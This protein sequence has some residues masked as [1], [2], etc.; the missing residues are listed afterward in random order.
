MKPETLSFIYTQN[1]LYEDSKKW[2]NKLKTTIENENSIDYD[3]DS[4]FIKFKEFLLDVCGQLK[5][6]E[7]SYIWLKRN[8]YNI[9]VEQREIIGLFEGSDKVATY[10]EAVTIEIK[11]DFFKKHIKG[12]YNL[13]FIDTNIFLSMGY[14]TGWKNSANLSS[15]NM[16]YVDI[17][18]ID[19]KIAN[20]DE[21]TIRNYIKTICPNDVLPNY[22]NASGHGF[23]L[24][25]LLDRYDLKTKDGFIDIKK[26]DYFININAKLITHFKA[27]TNCR[28]LG[29]YLRI[30]MSN[31]IKPNKIPVKS[32]LFTFTNRTRRFNL[33]ELNKAFDFVD[34]KK[35][36]YIEDAKNETV[37]KRKETLK[38]NKGMDRTLT[39][40]SSFNAFLNEYKIENISYRQILDKKDLEG[41]KTVKGKNSKILRTHKFIIN[42]FG[43][44]L[45][46][47]NPTIKE[48]EEILEIKE[49]YNEA[50][51]RLGIEE[52]KDKKIIIKERKEIEKKKKITTKEKKKIKKY[53]LEDVDYYEATH[54]TKNNTVPRDIRAKSQLERQ[55]NDFFYYAKEHGYI[56]EGRR[57]LCAVYMCYLLKNMRKLDKK[58]INIVFSMLSVC[59]NIDFYDDLY[60]IIIKTL[61]KKKKKQVFS[62]K[63]E[64]MLSILE[65]NEEN[66]DNYFTILNKEKRN[67]EKASRYRERKKIKKQEDMINKLPI[68]I[69]L[70]RNK[71][72]IDK[73]IYS[74]E[75]IEKAKEIIKKQD[76]N[77]FNKERLTDY[78]RK[79]SLIYD[80]K[81]TRSKY[82]PRLERIERFIELKK[83][84]KTHEEIMRELNISK[85]TYDSYS[86][87]SLLTKN[88]KD[89]YYN[90]LLPDIIKDLIHAKRKVRNKSKKYLTKMKNLKLS[91]M[92]ENRKKFTS[93]DIVNKKQFV[94][95]FMEELGLKD[96]IYLRERLKE[97]ICGF[98]IKFDLN[99]FETSDSVEVYDIKNNEL[100][101]YVNIN[102]K[103]LDEIIKNNFPKRFHEE[104]KENLSLP[105]SDKNY[106]YTKNWIAN[107]FATRLR[108][109]FFG[110]DDY[111]DY[112][113]KLDCGEI[114]LL[115]NIKNRI[116]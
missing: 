53:I 14:Y 51:K 66:E 95:I 11:E 52:K 93:F 115:K 23:H 77:I 67:R 55:L 4:N 41:L 94:D 33:E 39:N 21:E 16:I 113:R 89:I 20:G 68:L 5:K 13:S 87:E 97:K 18:G 81:I 86:L 103:N 105:W 22:V 60:N 114:I 84:N 78:K 62:L 49:A 90:N 26:R 37:R 106:I 15:V 111:A 30:P 91:L 74:E 57:N 9:P 25:W 58:D 85:R 69:N 72:W 46:S 107:Y 79:M 70:I 31:N 50:C 38:K 29:R 12:L 24:I 45:S 100:E 92:K 102:R 54:Y 88:T 36:H 34:I 8:D 6:D 104:I 1:K 73:N 99:F 116:F 56:R 112:I 109:L 28:D 61:S 7:V 108:N 64:T 2:I 47:L 10:S 83:E 48:A 42:I 110:M 71:K 17:D 63:N 19:E 44:K 98:K 76:K 65:I 59:F 40:P 96:D 35:D 3:K 101:I 75:M 27:D 80:A 82:L 43:Q 32:R